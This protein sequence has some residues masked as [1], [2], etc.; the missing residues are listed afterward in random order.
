MLIALAPASGCVVLEDL[1]YQ[2]NPNSESLL[3]LFQRPPPAQAV[4]WA[5]DP[6]SADN[7]YRGISLLAN[8]PFGGEDVYLDLFTDSARDPDSAV[9]AASVRGLAHH[10]RPEHADEI[11]R[12][13]SDE[14]SLVRLEAARAAQR[15]HNPSIVPALFGRLDAETEDEHDV[16][17]AVAHA[18]GQYPQRRVLDRLVGALRD[19][20]LT[21]NRHAAEALTILTGQDL[22]IDPVAWLSFV[23]DAE[24]PFAEGSRYRYQ[25]FQRDMRLVE[26]IPLYPEPPSDPAAEPVGL[27]RV[28]Q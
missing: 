28:E 10:G 23:T 1:G 18:L 22:G 3:T 8:A 14:S 9:R 11:A 15:I 19:P 4:R 13:L 2:S 25:V 12:A 24:A 20:S 17:A 7:R 16:R 21:V 5:L 6:H 27:P 26:Y